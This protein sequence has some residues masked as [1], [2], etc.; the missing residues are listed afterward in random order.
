MKLKSTKMTYD[1]IVSSNAA[2]NSKNVQTPYGKIDRRL[3]D[4]KYHNVM[5]LKREL[6]TL[7]GF[8]EAVKND[9]EATMRMKA[10]QQLH[11]NLKQDGDTWTVELE[12]GSYQTLAHIV[13]ENP[14]IVAKAGFVE[15][16]ISG[17]MD[18]LEEMHDKKQY[19]L[20]LAPENI[21]IRKGDEMPMLLFHGSS[22]TKTIEPSELFADYEEY[23]AP[24]LMQRGNSTTQQSDIYS[25]GKLIKWLYV[26]GSMPYEYKKTVGTALQDNAKKR[27]KSIADMRE[28]ISKL[29]NKKRSIISL[30]SAVAVVLV[31]TGLYFELVPKA[32]DI[33]FVE[34]APKEPEESLLDQG[35]FDP[36]VE[37]L[38]DTS[39]VDSMTEEEA[40]TLEE[41]MKKAED[42]F[43]K[44]FTTEADKILSKVLNDSKMS[45][46]EKEF[47]TSNNHMREEL[48]EL[49]AD[50]AE[51][52]GI[53]DDRAGRITTEVL[54]KLYIEKQ[55]KLRK[56]NFQNDKKNR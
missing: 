49:Q 21:F 55:K 1:E 22:F 54:N 13:D 15:D 25:L 26:Q 12:T 51:K 23:L 8:T 35:G 27:F 31:V 14:A 56:Y 7:L 18:I 40:R 47:M 53:S 9:L 3:V 45:D 6:T 29:K 11:G 38:K 42:I 39:L 43:R 44:Q 10:K 17:L 48:L 34:P 28:S 30:V 52:A 50:L 24:E 32:E 19:A 4:K 41:Y 20:C 5:V 16:V 2:L 36:E 46:S 33:E 37:L